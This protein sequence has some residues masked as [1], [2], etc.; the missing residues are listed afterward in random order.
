MIALLRGRV[1]SR[2]ARGTVVLDV[3]GVGYRVSAAPR[4]VAAVGALGGEVVLHTHLN[5]REDALTLYGFATAEER[6]CFEA[7]IG[8]RGVGPSLALAI[9]SVHTPTELA[10]VLAEGDIDGLTLVPGVGRKTA[11]RLLVELKARLDMPLDGV[12][13]DLD[14]AGGALP[15]ARS[16]LRSALEG[17]GYGPEEIG[18]VLRDLPAE[19]DVE[20]LLRSALKLLA[21]AR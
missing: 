6:D 18:E 8:A 13:G 19:G 2:S 4:T 5:V 14:G 17:L 16:D 11:T 9:L 10:R 20:E 15:A 3:G 1:V 21:A 12:A 7:L